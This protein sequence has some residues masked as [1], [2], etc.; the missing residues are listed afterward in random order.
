MTYAEYC[1]LKETATKNAPPQ[2]VVTQDAKGNIVV[3]ITLPP[4]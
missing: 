4:P 2:I 3:T 1:A